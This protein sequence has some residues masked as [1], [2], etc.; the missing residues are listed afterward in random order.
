MM[1]RNVYLRRWKDGQYTRQHL[2]GL[3]RWEL[4][5]ADVVHVSLRGIALTINQRVCA[6]LPSPTLH[7]TRDCN[8]A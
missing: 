6:A 3:D 8:K 5:A 4:Q 2:D 1:H 7:G